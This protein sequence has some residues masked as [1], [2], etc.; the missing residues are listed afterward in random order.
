MSE[1]NMTIDDWRAGI[2]SIDEELLRL[3]NRRA[4]LVANIAALKAARAMP[5]RDA[6]RE[7]AVLERARCAVVS[8]LDEAGMSRIFQR[9][10]V[11][12]R[13]VQSRVIAEAKGARRAKGE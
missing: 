3:L 9:I 5:L 12:S 7:S 11:E 13:R 1:T 8:P 4:Q 2:D 10:L 6:E